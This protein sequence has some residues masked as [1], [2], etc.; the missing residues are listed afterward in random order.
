MFGDSYLR[1]QYN[2]NKWTNTGLKNCCTFDFALLFR[3]FLLG[4][5][6]GARA[7]VFEAVTSDSMGRLQGSEQVDT[8]N[9]IPGEGE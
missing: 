7:R 2:T 8:V 1:L 9:E 3:W 6:R 4:E 5:I